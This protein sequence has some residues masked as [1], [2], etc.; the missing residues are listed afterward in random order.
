MKHDTRKKKRILVGYDK[1][2][3]AYLVYF[4]NKKEMKK[5]RFQ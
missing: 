1:G 4:P 3:L 2:N 5:V